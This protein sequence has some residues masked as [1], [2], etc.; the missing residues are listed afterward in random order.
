MPSSILPKE[1]IG[2]FSGIENWISL[3]LLFDVIIIMRGWNVSKSK[4]LWRKN[5]RQKCLFVRCFYWNK[6]SLLTKEK[7]KNNICAERKAFGR[8]DFYCSWEVSKVKKQLFRLWKACIILSFKVPTRQIRL[9]LK[10]YGWIG[11]GE[12]KDRRW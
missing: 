9:G 2:T 3:F 7:Y 1:T 4:Y 10:C 5:N 8:R 11:L 12:Y 6:S